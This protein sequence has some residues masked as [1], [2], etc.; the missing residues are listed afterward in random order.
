MPTVEMS[1]RWLERVKLPQ[2]GRIDFFD[3]KVTGLGLR[4]SFSGKLVWFV[5]FRVKGDTKLRRLTLDAY[6]AMPLA[7][8]RERAHEVVLAA[9][10]GQDPAATFAD[11]AAEYITRY[12]MPNKRSWVEDQRVLNKDVLPLWG[13][14][15]AHD[16]TR[17]DVIA[18]LDRIHERGAPIGANRTLALVRKVF[19]WA[20]SRDLLETNPCQQVKTVAAEN[21][22]DRV[23]SESE[24]RA[25]WCA[26]DGEGVP[27][28]TMFKLRLLTAQRGGEIEKMRWDEIDMDSG[29]WT[30]SAD[31]AKNGLSHRV[32]LSAQTLELL[33]VQRDGAGDSVWVFP[34][35]KR[36]IG[37]ICTTQHA[38]ERLQ[39]ASGVAFVPHDLRRTAASYMTGMGISRL[40]VS[41]LLNHV[42]QGITR[43]YDRH[44]YDAEKREA[45]DTWAERVATILVPAPKTSGAAGPCGHEL[46]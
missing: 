28:G 30:I 34:S 44:S 17:R 7:G 42:E 13:R 20:I 18:L 12:A 11:L 23:L 2:A 46:R 8:A 32:P 26:C 41:K 4:V 43:V 31:V 25:V 29:W 27:F 39:V 10:R 35:R 1:A 3:E 36:S 9:S 15:K 16:I 40:V 45:L 19:N 33:R 21:Q 38:A 24:I 37:H 14:R 5:M 6:P 22:S